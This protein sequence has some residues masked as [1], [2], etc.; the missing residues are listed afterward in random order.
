LITSEKHHPPAGVI[1][2]TFRKQKHNLPG[3]KLQERLKN[4]YLPKP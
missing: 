4:P 1:N 2:F 3:W